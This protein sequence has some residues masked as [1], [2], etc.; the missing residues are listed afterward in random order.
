MTIQKVPTTTI[1][2]HLKEI[3][4]KFVEDRKYFKANHLSVFRIILYLNIFN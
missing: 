1:K 4:F 3:F 2:H